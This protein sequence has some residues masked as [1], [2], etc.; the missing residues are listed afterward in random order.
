MLYPMHRITVNPRDK[1]QTISTCKYTTQQP[2]CNKKNY[3]NV[4]NFSPSLTV[5]QQQ[6]PEFLFSTVTISL[7]Y[8]WFNFDSS[9][10]GCYFVLIFV[11]GSKSISAPIE[12]RNF[13]RGFRSYYNLLR[14]SFSEHTERSPVAHPKSPAICTNIA[15]PVPTKSPPRQIPFLCLH[16][17]S[18]SAIQSGKI[19]CVFIF[20]SLECKVRS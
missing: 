20:F 7:N 9:S 19:S 2:N 18:A 14:Y 1:I 10:R 5:F 11:L 3:N 4:L 17:V 13:Q 16:S 6:H 8:H 15:A 12:I